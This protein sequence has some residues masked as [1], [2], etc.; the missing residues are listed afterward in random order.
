MQLYYEAMLQFIE[1]SAE[2][3]NANKF[4]LYSF[5]INA[6]VSD[7]WLEK[8]QAHVYNSI[9]QRID[10]DEYRE[11]PLVLLSSKFMPLIKAYNAYV[12][13]S[14]EANPYS[15]R[16]AFFMASNRSTHFFESIIHDNQEIPEPDFIHNEAK[17]VKLAMLI[18]NKPTR[19]NSDFNFYAEVWKLF[20]QIDSVALSDNQRV[21]YNEFAR[22]L[23][24]H[25]FVRSN[26]R[27]EYLSDSIAIKVLASKYNILDFFVK[28]ND[29]NMIMNTSDYHLVRKQ[30]VE[31]GI[32][33]RLINPDIKKDGTKASEINLYDQFYTIFVMIEV[34][35][36]RPETRNYEE[37][38]RT[39]SGEIKQII[40][41]IDDPFDFIE[42]IEFLFN[43]L[44]LRFEHV[45]SRVFSNGKLVHT[46]TSITT[47]QDSDSSIEEAKKV[48]PP[49]KNGF[50]CTFVV[51]QNMLNAL[52]ASIINRKTDELTE[53]L[54]QRYA[55]MTSVIDDAKWRLQLV[56]MFYSTKNYLRAPSELKIML[57]SR[58]KQMNS[59]TAISTSSDEVDRV[60][61]VPKK[62]TSARRR[63]RRTNSSKK[64]SRSSRS[65]RSGKSDTFA[66]STEI[67]GKER[68][69]SAAFDA[70]SISAIRYASYRDRRGFMGK[71]LGKLTDM[72][73]ISVIRGDLNAAKTIIEVMT[74]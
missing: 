32:F 54:K 59:K 13:H 31:N 56:D 45:N 68:K 10:T 26:R 62:Q 60:V 34:L 22:M 27:Y 49:V 6:H 58:Q 5:L 64:S 71:M 16:A 36:L 61:V 46:S 30:L 73:T 15:K 25:H 9:F 24:L 7:K 66:N 1:F 41:N 35:L 23:S 17:L 29:G 40:E 72:V 21:L 48:P 33:N 67:E 28:F 51:I 38:V 43:L 52:S 4:N 3:M 14:C 47:L 74:F 12:N 63:S 65:S 39:K 44:F 11:L 8:C 18:S 2:Q 37:I 55:R 69:R 70:E 19:P 50:A 42:A 53:D 57:T 20:E